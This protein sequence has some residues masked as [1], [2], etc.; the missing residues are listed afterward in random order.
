MNPEPK[1]STFPLYKETMLEYDKAVVGSWN[2]HGERT[3]YMSV[4]PEFEDDGPNGL[5]D[6]SLEQTQQI[7]DGLT[8]LLDK[9]KGEDS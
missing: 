5:Y 1:E 2:Y 6:L 7:V 4:P 9:Y 3:Y 8:R